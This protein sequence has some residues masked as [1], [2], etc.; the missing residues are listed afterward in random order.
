M[1]NMWSSVYNMS[2]V[3]KIM[4]KQIVAVFCQCFLKTE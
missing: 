2:H 4:Y 1:K 3:R